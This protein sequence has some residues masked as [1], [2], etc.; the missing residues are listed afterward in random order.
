MS[1]HVSFHFTGD[2]VPKTYDEIMV[3]RMFNP[4]ARRLIDQAKIQVGDQVLDMA[5]GPGTV[6]R[7]LAE[8][9][10]TEGLVVGV[11]MS[12]PM[13][14][15]A[16][17]KPLTPGAGKIEYVESQVTPLILP[18]FLNEIKFDAV[19]CQQA[20]QFFPEK[21]A[22]LK[23]M[24]R[25]VRPGGRVVFSIWGS[26]EECQLWKI[27]RDE[28]KRHHSEAAA[29]VME[30]PFSFYDRAQIENLLE[31]AGFEKAVIDYHSMP[32]IF[33]GGPDQAIAALY[34]SPLAQ[35]ILEMGEEA[36]EAMEEDFRREITS[37]LDENGAVVASNAAHTVIAEF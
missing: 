36:R 18:E 19:T 33:E 29:K 5:C 1:E 22:A 34:G 17:A 35:F 21:A 10:G 25:R 4:W 15:V 6:A 11:D 27:F 2:S 31:E 37:L 3:P 28:L 16:R 26:I 8:K 7:L 13:L 23:E 24:K 32:A 14:E 30:A 20:V 9:V 12:L